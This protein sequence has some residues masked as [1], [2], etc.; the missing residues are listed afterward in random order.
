M[1]HLVFAELQEQL[2]L[3]LVGRDFAVALFGVA[4][5]LSPD[6]LGAFVTVTREIVTHSHDA[7]YLLTPVTLLFGVQSHGPTQQN[8][9][10]LSYTLRQLKSWIDVHFIIRATD[11]THFFVIIYNHMLISKET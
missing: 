8:T 11:L 7:E 10:V 6:A 4:D 3:V 1:R 9:S 5:G 2:I